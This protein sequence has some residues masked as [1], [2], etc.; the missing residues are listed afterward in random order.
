MV[1]HLLQPAAADWRTVALAIAAEADKANQD[2]TFT[3]FIRS[4]DLKLR[5]LA[6]A[7]QPANVHP[8]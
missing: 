7:Q 3:S 6:A 4:V 5:E 8:I 2:D 1:R